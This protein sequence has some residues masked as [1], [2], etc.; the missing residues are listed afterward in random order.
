MIDLNLN[1]IQKEELLHDD[2]TKDFAQALFNPDK[3]NDLFRQKLQQA[4]NDLLESELTAFLG[5]NPYDSLK[6]NIGGIEINAEELI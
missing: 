4:V 6:R 2:F 5:Y 1:N 3:I